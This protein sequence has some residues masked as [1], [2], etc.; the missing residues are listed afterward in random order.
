MNAGTGRHEESPVEILETDRKYF[1]EEYFAQKR[2]IKSFE[3]IKDQGD[4]LMFRSDDPV[5]RYQLFKLDIT[6]KSYQDFSNS[7]LP[8][9]D[10]TFGIAGTLIDR[11]EPN[12]KYYY[13]ARSI[14][15]HENVS[16]PTHIFEIEMIDNNGQIFLKQKVFN[17][18]K[19]HENFVKSGRRFIYIEPSL[20]QLVFDPA[21][22]GQSLDS[23][24][25]GQDPP[26]NL[27]G[28]QGVTDQV[29]G[30]G[31]KVRLTSKK[32]GRKMDLNINFTNTGKVKPSE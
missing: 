22:C 2:E 10:P 23:P 31:F 4:K 19:Q 11:I 1:E 3:D 27:L 17:F 29:W 7:L 15:M 14:D 32:T 24:A 9:I 28:A 21:G 30:K 18:E 26:T 25:L 16:N 13:C 5:D 6:P 12:R 8:E 20:Q